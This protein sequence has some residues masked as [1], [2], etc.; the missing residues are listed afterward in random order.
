MAKVNISDAAKLA[1]ISR[2]TL[3]KKYIQPGVISVDKD[4]RGHPVIDTS[5]LLRVFGNIYTAKH[6]DGVNALLEETPKETT[7]TVSCKAKI[8]A[9]EALL[10]QQKQELRQAREE[11]AW[12]RQRVEA[13]EQ[14]QLA[15]PGTT[16]RWWWPW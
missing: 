5:E 8:E 2:V 11:I 6:K 12:L 10:E 7:E 1:R 14:K 16:K 3:Y 15:G 9:L 4:A 13:A